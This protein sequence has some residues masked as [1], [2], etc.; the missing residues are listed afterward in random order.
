MSSDDRGSL[1][2]AI[3]WTALLGLALGGLLIVDVKAFSVG[4]RWG[5]LL[6]GLVWIA[7]LV[8]RALRGWSEGD[9]GAILP[10]RRSRRAKRPPPI[11][12]LVDLERLMEFASATAFDVHYR[13]RPR[14]IG[15]AT[16]RLARHGVTLTGQPEQA[17][18]MVG[19]RAWAL[20][21]PDRPPPEQRHGP[22][23]QSA[24]LQQIVEE[25]DAL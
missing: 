15:I 18:A 17:R 6:I 25:I 3:G 8:H 14:L 22:G 24:E 12:Q 16:H 9:G 11:P 2:L 19:A 1:S 10:R 23:I 4:L 21:R 7:Y 20:I 13:L 5:M